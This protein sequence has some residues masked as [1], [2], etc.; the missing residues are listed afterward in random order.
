[1]D[2]KV[3]MIINHKDTLYVEKTR[4]F[5]SRDASDIIVKY[6]AGR[7]EYEEQCFEPHATQ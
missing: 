1:M 7:K 5:H 2:G 4:Y 6:K 3:G